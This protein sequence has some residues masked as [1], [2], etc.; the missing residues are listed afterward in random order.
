MEDNEPGKI[1]AYSWEPN[2]AFPPP[3]NKPSSYGLLREK[4]ED[5]EDAVECFLLCGGGRDSDSMGFFNGIFLFAGK[6]FLSPEKRLCKSD[7]G[8][9]EERVRM[10]AVRVRR[11]GSDGTSG[12]PKPKPK[13]KNQNQNQNCFGVP[14]NQSQ[15]SK[16]QR[17]VQAIKVVEY[18]AKPSHVPSP[19][20]DSRNIEIEVQGLQAH[21]HTHILTHGSRERRRVRSAFFLVGML[22]AARL[23]VTQARE[24]IRGRRNFHLYS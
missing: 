10:A 5:V 11:F 23:L 1:S 19:C 16:Y 2:F 13:L 14:G 18:I 3:E 22:V 24:R 7:N 12:H 17:T 21:T 20:P 15:I 9:K 6:G 4:E 8:K